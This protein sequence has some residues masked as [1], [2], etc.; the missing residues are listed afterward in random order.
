MNK[1]VSVI[2]IGALFSTSAYAGRTPQGEGGGAAGAVSDT[3]VTSTFAPD[4]AASLALAKKLQAELYEEEF[5]PEGG[6]QL[7][8]SPA[9]A[10]I[11][12]ND[13][14]L[15]DDDGEDDDPYVSM[16]QDGHVDLYTEY[17]R[18]L[19]AELTLMAKPN[20]TVFSMNKIR[21]GYPKSVIDDAIK[22]DRALRAASVMQ[23]SL[24][25]SQVTDLP[26][27]ADLRA[28]RRE[29]IEA[30]IALKRQRIA[31]IN[32]DDDDDDDDV[33][34]FELIRL[35]GEIATL[36]AEL[37]ALPTSTATYGA[38]TQNR[39]HLAAEFAVEIHDTSDDDDVDEDDLAAAIELSL[40]K[41]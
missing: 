35:Q 15:Y 33:L 8:N 6:Y 12:L 11:H 28:R 16:N 19:L 31:Q 22:A 39:D 26:G 38:L 41:S 9:L 24:S 2:L 17:E 18:Q 21:D 3:T 34:S 13:Q 4:E 27:S 20:Y 29:E 25:M 10:Q 7:G 40:S 14:A 1:L 36:R 32:Q 37:N 23:N 30:Q 5:R